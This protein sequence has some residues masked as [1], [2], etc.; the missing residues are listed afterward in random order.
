MNNAET[1]SSFI[2]GEES[3]LIQASQTLL[4]KGHKIEGIIAAA[5][6][7]HEWALAH[8]IPMIDPQADLVSV[9]GQRPFDYFF[10]ITNLSIIPEAV[11]ALPQKGAINFHDG[12]LPRYAG[13]YATTWALLNREKQHGV[14]WHTMTAAVDKGEIL[15][16]KL[17]AITSDETAFTLNVKCYQAGIES[18]AQ[19]VDELAAGTNQPQPQNL[20]GQTY[21]GKYHRPQGTAVLD[22]NQPADR[23]AATVRALD[24]GSYANPVA[25]P[26]LR[27]E[28]GLFVVK[29]T[30]VHHD[31]ATA[32]P[33]TIL[34]T[35]ETGVVIAA[36]QGSV[37]ITQLQTLA[38]E[39]IAGPDI[40][41]RLGVTGGGRLPQP[42]DESLHSLHKTIARQEGY[43]VRRLVDLTPLEIPYAQRRSDDFQ[44]ETAVE[45]IPEPVRQYLAK[46]EDIPSL[47]AALIAAAAAF[48]ARLSG[49]YEFAV[50]FTHPALAQTITG[51][52]PLFAGHVPLSLT[53]SPQDKAGETLASLSQAVAQ[54]MGKRHTFCRDVFLRYPQLTGL[55]E[56]DDRALSPVTL[57]LVDDPKTYQPQPGTELAILA[58][59]DG[60]DCCWVYDT[61]VYTPEAIHAMQSQ[62]ATFLY[63]V[64]ADD[65]R[66]LAYISH[67]SKSEL[68][69]LLVEWN[70]TDADYPDDLCIHHLFEMQ[71]GRIPA[72]TAVVFHDQHISYR[73][74]NERANQLAYHLR[75]L[76]VGPET[77]VGVYMNRSLELIVGLLG[78]LKAGGAYLPLDPGYPAD[79]IAFMLLDADVPV[80]L[81]Q[82]DLVAQ[83]PPHQAQLVQMDADGDVIARQPTTNIRSRAMPENLAYV[84]YTS[85]STGK[86]KGV[87]V[88]HGNVVN[89]CAGM[90]ERIPYYAPGTWL[91]VTSLSFD[92]SALEIF[93]SL[94]R[95]FKLV[96]YD[97]YS[98]SET[99]VADIQA[100]RPIDFSLFYFASDESEDGVA[101]KYH[102]LLEGAKYGDQNGFTAVWTP[103]RHF[104]AFGGL[105]PNPSIA[106]AA[107]AAVTERIHIRAGSC[108]L[109]LHSPIRVAEEWSLVDN[110]SRGRV[111]VG[112]AAG[113]Q[114]NDFVLRPGNYADRKE[115][116]FR[117]IETVQRLWRG[118]TI[119]M[120]NDLGKDVAVKTLPHPIQPE[121]PIWITAANNPET[122]RMAGERGFSVLTHLLGQSAEE[123]A[124]KIA[125][126]RRAWRAADHPGSGHI[127]LMLHTFIGEDDDEVR[128]IVRGPMTEYLKSAMALVRQAAWH[129]PTFKERAQATGQSPFEIFDSEE[130]TE[131]DLT[132]V[133]DFAFERYFESSGLF[134]A[135]QTA[136]KMVNKLKAIEVDEIA[137]LIDYGV[138]SAQVLAQLPSLKQVLDMSQ[139]DAT[140]RDYSIPA[141]IQ[142][143]HATHFQCTPS[144]ASM[145]LIDEANRS[146]YSQLDVWLV[147]GEAFPAALAQ[148]MQAMLTDRCVLNMYGPTETTI[149]SSTHQLAGE[150]TSISIGRPIANTTI[151]LLD[152]HGQ[153]VPTGLPGELHIGGDGV[154]RG[155]HNRSDLNEA[156]F[157]PD[158][159]R[160]K[161]GARMYRTGDL[162]RYLPD[163]RIEFLGR[164][165]F[166]V[167]I[168]GYRIELGEI[169]TLLQQHTAVREAVVTAR[170]DTPGD[171][172]LAAYLI[173]Q[174]GQTV[175]AA[176][177]RQHL[178]AYLPD[179]MLPAHFIPMDAFPLTPNKK[180][181][182]KALPAPDEVAPESTAVYQPPTND[183]EQTI[184]DIWK[185][186]L[187]VP[188][189]GL[190]DNFF[191]LGGHS[192]LAV[193][194]H[195][196]LRQMI[197]REIAI[198]DMF[199]F[200]T[201]RTLSNYLS[202]GGTNGSPRQGMAV[203]ASLDRAAARRSRMKN[204]RRK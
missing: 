114:P 204:R 50:N 134:G 186:L 156:R 92:I 68:Y 173:P 131:E 79:R 110:L 98:Q 16:Q 87:M 76:G 77:R 106:S 9:L 144:M 5:M 118:E 172:R 82:S 153:P 42:S 74:L 111:G 19:L 197:D 198:T 158:P 138:P 45:S 119:T 112:F 103:E 195:R 27:A 54:V 182:R 37:H 62:L 22:W 25:L 28:T 1:F 99:A 159:F 102:L 185:G 63:N 180:T 57:A 15:K 126:Y 133:L 33:G 47:G 166:Q 101:D 20:A 84:I 164:A 23:I 56:R 86:P 104:H 169:E 10:S 128:E 188:Q 149:W 89:F 191:D 94:A 72:D 31:A 141:L 108:V 142:R 38:G 161:P 107:I 43:W 12:P 139:P 52:E 174:P 8:G 30:A 176:E 13:L 64:M 193:Q 115:I 91:T 3:L 97:G 35:D 14:T 71:A 196:R 200:P 66:S 117:D 124:E 148:E 183:L 171:K 2:M 175:I 48:L 113:W 129:F 163:G 187:N 4:E 58:T 51:Y 24:F 100:E 81:T 165:D 194:A 125:L 177:L 67:L 184:A 70:E 59:P 181:D 155:Y 202:Q 65:G 189:V 53:L 95:G 120:T 34:Q 170:E 80:L 32:Q 18:F 121:L 40:A 6:S 162:A 135:P 39:M 88:Q 136:I 105:Y 154:V 29:A 132:A 96:M 178:R 160:Q 83:L 109:P 116:M 11:L 147:G 60:A 152:A 157:L 73:E 123:L 55:K 192:L 150:E 145:L 137:C 61:A 122:F 75:A 146:V 36:Y 93:W 199:R 69:R 26:K 90:D 21:F 167:K 7:I 78:I 179:F 46:Q 49:Q 203:A 41:V 168:R 17:F 130:L 44:Y 151:Y 201:V 143:H 85:G 127:T 140:L 190:S